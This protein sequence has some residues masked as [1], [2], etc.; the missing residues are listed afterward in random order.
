MSAVCRTCIYHYLADNK[1][2]PICEVQVHKTKP[3]ANVR[4]VE[5]N[6]IN[7]VPWFQHPNNVGCLAWW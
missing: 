3:L 6:Y 4:Y 1:Y 5:Y 2:C 7:K